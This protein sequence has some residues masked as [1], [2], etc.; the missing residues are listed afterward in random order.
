MMSSDYSQ[1]DNAVGVIGLIA[2]RM[3]E[4]DSLEAVLD[5]SG[6]GVRAARC[7]EAGRAAERFMNR[8]RHR[9][10]QTHRHRLTAAPA[11]RPHLDQ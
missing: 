7:V 6:K 5:L 8:S 1:W 2:H 9:I 3:S 4:G 10:L 11:R